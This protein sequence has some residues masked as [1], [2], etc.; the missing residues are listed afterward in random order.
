MKL[1]AISLIF[2]EPTTYVRER[3]ELPTVM[4]ETLHIRT[5][6]GHEETCNVVKLG[7]R[8]E[9]GKTLEMSALVVP[10][11]C[12]PLVSQPITAS[13]ETH[14]HLPGLEL[15]DSADGSDVLEVDMT[16]RSDWY[17]NLVTNG[18]SV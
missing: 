13:G 9:K 18:C 8:I 7:V 3:L 11:I 12:S 17:C 2:S 5:F 4:T 1:C 14:D 15:A 16:I 10:L 6:G